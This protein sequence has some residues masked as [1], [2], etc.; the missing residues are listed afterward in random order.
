MESIGGKTVGQCVWKSQ[1]GAQ[2][3]VL[4][5]PK[6]QVTQLAGYTTGAPPAR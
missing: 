5:Y 2:A 6:A 4:V 1:L 3:I